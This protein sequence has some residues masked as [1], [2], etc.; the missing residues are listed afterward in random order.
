MGCMEYK[1]N[2]ILISLGFA[3]SGTVKELGPLN[4]FPSDPQVLY[5]VPQ[6][7][8]KRSSR[9]S[10]RSTKTMWTLVGTQFGES[11]DTLIIHLNTWT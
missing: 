10:E 2:Y 6:T 1:D 9:F 4:I 11:L 8:S 3:L 5:L 7:L